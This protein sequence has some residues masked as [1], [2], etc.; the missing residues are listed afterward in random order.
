MQ[1]TDFTNC[2]KPLI[3][4]NS[5]SVFPYSI[6]GTCFLAKFGSA[7]YVVTARH[8]LVQRALDSM[9]IRLHPGILAFCKLTPMD[10]PETR[11]GD[12]CDLAIFQIQSGSV[13]PADLRS[14]NFLDLNPHRSRPFVLRE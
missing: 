3:F 1:V 14:N 10:V 13:S 2:A 6:Q 7:A 5:D 12:S 11:E 9:R 8:C 4:E